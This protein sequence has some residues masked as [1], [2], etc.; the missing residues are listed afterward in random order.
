[1]DRRRLLD[2]HVVSQ[3]GSQAPDREGTMTGELTDMSSF[4]C[5]LHDATRDACDRPDPATAAVITTLFAQAFEAVDNPLECC[6]LMR[7]IREKVGP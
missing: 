4:V 6:R 7:L 2:A 3:T 5:G 1:M